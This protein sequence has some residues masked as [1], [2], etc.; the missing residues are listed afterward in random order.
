[1]KD[2]IQ[3]QKRH[4][5]GIRESDRRVIEII[6]KL[7]NDKKEQK[8]LDLGCSTGNLLKHIKKAFPKFSLVGGDLSSLQIEHCNNQPELSDIEFKLI[9]AT[10]IGTKNGYDI[11]ILNAVLF[12]LDD[13]AFNSALNS[14][15]AALKPDG[16]LI[17]FDLFH[18]WK[19]DLTIIEK[20]GSIPEGFVLR[21]RPI[22]VVKHNLKKAGFLSATFEPFEIPID[23]PKPPSDTNR[24]ETYTISTV[25]KNRIQMR[26]CLSQ[27]WCHLIAI[28]S[29][30]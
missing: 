3:Y 20:S 14:I 28:K 22:D 7:K 1:M 25:D 21:F 29:S 26:G 30:I 9:D 18:E 27:P 4:S 24:L 11:I 13:D 5:L 23:L 12:S 6:T 16:V 2:Y 8:L 10:N 17:A 15:F 19:Q